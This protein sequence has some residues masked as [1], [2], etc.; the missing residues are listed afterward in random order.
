MYAATA[1]GENVAL[2]SLDGTD[3]PLFL[4]DGSWGADGQPTVE[5]LAAILEHLAH[6]VF[7]KDRAFRYLLVNR[8]L[9]EL[10]GCTRSQMLGKFDHDFMSQA[11]A[12]AIRR[13]D[14]ELF[15]SQGRVSIDEQL[16]TDARGQR[17]VLSATKVPLQGADGT[18]QY[19]VGIIHDVTRLKAAEEELRNVNERLEQRIEERTGALA[20]AQ[21]QLLRNERLAVLGQIAGGLAHQIRNPLGSITNAG[22]IL[23]RLLSRN[24][25]QDMDEPTTIILEEAWKANRIITGL[26][27]YARARPA[28]NVACAAHQVLRA[29]LRAQV[30]PD[31]IQIQDQVPELPEALADPDQLREVFANLLQNAIDA[32]PSGGTL[33][34][35]GRVDEQSCS[36]TVILDIA[37]TGAGVPASVR[38]RLFQPLV[39]TKPSGIGLGLTTARMLVENQGGTISVASEPGQGASFRVILPVAAPPGASEPG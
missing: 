27:D 37:D 34:L 39:S 12:E 1:R 8:A 26:L 4:T 13:Q 16:F 17:H 31:C 11:E 21:E 23:K 15:K 14:T 6:P 24:A 20:R 35:T 18:A 25:V 29:T 32:M 36:R 30:I 38:A 22:Y 2:D 10:T 3:A 28:H 9:C 7:V 19:L 33:S 5:L